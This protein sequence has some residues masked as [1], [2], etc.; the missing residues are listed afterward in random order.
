[1]YSLSTQ[2]P[3]WDVPCLLAGDENETHS[4]PLPGRVRPAGPGIPLLLILEDH[5]TWLGPQS[6]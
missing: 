1:M 6:L 2:A 4:H 3:V 5:L